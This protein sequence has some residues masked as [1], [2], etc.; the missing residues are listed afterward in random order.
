MI[1]HSILAG[2]IYDEEFTRKSIPFLKGEYFS[3]RADTV[4]FEEINKHLQE[5]NVR[6]SKS[7]LQVSIDNRTDL[8][9]DQAKQTKDLIQ[10][11]EYDPQTDL[12]WMLDNTEKHCQDK[13]IYNAVK[14]SILVLDGNNK[15]LDRGAIPQLLSDALGVSFDTAIGH[16]FLDDF[17][18]RYDFY[19]TKENK[20]EFDIEMLNKITKGGVSR[21]ALCVALASTGVGK[22]LFMCHAAAANLMAGLNVLYIT[23]EMA[24]ER[25]AERI[26]ANLLDWT[27]DDLRDVP[28]DVYTSRISSVMK[29]TNGKLIVKEY[30]TGS[31]NANHFRFLLNELKLKKKF[32]PDVIYV[33]YLNICA[34]SRVKMSG[35]VN[36]YTYIKSIAEELRGLAVEFNV[37]VFTATQSN[38]DGANN[39][40]IDLTNTSESWGLPATADFMFALISTEELEQVG[41]LM[42]KQLKNRWGDIST[43]KRFVVGIDRPKMRLFDADDPEGKMVDDRPVMSKS[44]FGERDEGENNM[45]SF[46]TGKA[47]RPA[48]GGFS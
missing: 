40:D 14:E 12:Q 25:I 23:M 17:A 30:P 48:F 36:S 21:K 47:K 45:L 27:L 11:L 42:I 18:S 26:D 3:E 4:I 32:I 9:E 46:N 13:A 43:H 8:N 6:P 37:P 33:D 35:S 16:D 34:S 19:H 38:R 22:T 41:Q 31:A 20:I 29:R 1:E 44:S 7:V 10:S 15:T 28:K 5:Y 39:S 24:E 2:L